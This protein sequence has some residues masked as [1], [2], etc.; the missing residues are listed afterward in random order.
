MKESL[1]SFVELAKPDSISIIVGKFLL[2]A[3]IA[4]SLVSLTVSQ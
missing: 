4:S 2:K 3:I 1:S